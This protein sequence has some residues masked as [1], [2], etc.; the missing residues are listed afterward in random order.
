MIERYAVVSLAV[1]VCV[2]VISAD[3]IRNAKAIAIGRHIVALHRSRTPNTMN[4][5]KLGNEEDDE[6]KMKKTKSKKN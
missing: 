4:K 2:C 3:A 6:V 1:Y 5:K